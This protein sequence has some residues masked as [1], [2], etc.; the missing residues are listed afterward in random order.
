MIPT[1][2]NGMPTYFRSLTWRRYTIK[3]DHSAITKL[4]RQVTE[5][6]K[7]GGMT[8]LTNMRDGLVVENYGGAWYAC[9]R[10]RMGRCD[11][12]SDRLWDHGRRLGRAPVPSL[13]SAGLHSGA[14]GVAL[15]TATPH[16]S[17]R[18]PAILRECGTPRLR[19]F[20]FNRSR[21]PRSHGTYSYHTWKRNTLRSSPS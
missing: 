13:R 6:M 5:R 11:R 18:I 15:S 3:P 9:S 14:A 16:S 12:A 2:R 20:R 1:G 8:R 19:G 7:R 4:M 21:S 17:F 10:V